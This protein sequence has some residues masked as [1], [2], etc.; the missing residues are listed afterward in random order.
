M[1]RELLSAR[2]R[3]Y[4]LPGSFAA[5]ARAARAA[6]TSATPVIRLTVGQPHLPPPGHV[7]EAFAAANRA[8][9]GHRY[10][11]VGG[12][13][14]LRELVAAR[15]AV[16]YRKPVSAGEVVVTVGAKGAVA[17]ALEVLL[18]PGDEV[19]LATPCWSG[20][21]PAIERAGGVAVLA[22]DPQNRTGLLT[23]ETVRRF[24]GAR[25]RAVV[26]NSPTN[27]TGAMYTA[28][29]LRDLERATAALPN[30]AAVLSDE[31]Y[32]DVVFT[33]ESH[34]PAARVIGAVPVVTVSGW[35]KCY[36]M[37]G[38]RLGYATGPREVIAAMEA[39]QGIASYPGTAAQHAA[40][41][42]HS[43]GGAFPRA[44]AAHY[45]A[46]GQAVRAR[47][48]ELTACG[49]DLLAEPYGGFF[50]FLDVVAL[51]S[52]LPVELG[53]SPGDRAERWLLDTARVGVSSGVSFCDPAAVR[54]SLAVGSAEMNEAL[55]RI[56]AAV[57]TLPAR[58]GGST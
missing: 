29:G 40:L 9:H 25:T 26:L 44:L 39:L 30:C 48:P 27:P 41:A 33:P 38:D 11:P 49:L 4:R 7:L 35:S 8:P 37:T 56:L 22:V 47:H 16:A 51:A 54:V 10:P 23:A 24:G 45:A 18:D 3:A 15:A 52:R 21:V 13:P 36:A 17:N 53:G 42:A 12:L 57:R 31:I 43:D 20:F 1:P 5:S 46:N 6:A 32:A 14:Q 55:D 2:A 50:V 19:L 28:D 58:R 34:V